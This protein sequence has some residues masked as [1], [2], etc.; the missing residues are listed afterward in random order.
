ML[1]LEDICLFDSSSPFDPE[2]SLI[3]NH[4]NNEKK[5]S[6]KIAKFFWF[7]LKYDVK[8]YYKKLEAR[9]KS[10]ISINKTYFDHLIFP[11]SSFA[12]FYLSHLNLKTN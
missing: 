7:N 10:I 2:D 4:Y 8:N 5:I 3:N 6:G 12:S 9:K 11:T 1:N